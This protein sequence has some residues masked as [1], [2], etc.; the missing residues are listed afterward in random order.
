MPPDVPEQANNQDDTRDQND[1]RH[2]ISLPD[3]KLLVLR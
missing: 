2:W 1:T 3:S